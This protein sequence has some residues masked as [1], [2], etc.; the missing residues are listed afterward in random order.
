MMKLVITIR[1]F[2]TLYPDLWAARIPVARSTSQ[3]GLRT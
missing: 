1:E 3:L 2:P